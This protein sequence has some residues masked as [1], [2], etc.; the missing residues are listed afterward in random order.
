[1]C[2]LI[3]GIFHKLSTRPMQA[4]RQADSVAKAT[5]KLIKF[6][7]ALGIKE[8]SFACKTVSDS[9]VKEWLSG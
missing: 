8:S 2:Q 7:M 1:M 6:L 4:G 3:L 9:I 5:N